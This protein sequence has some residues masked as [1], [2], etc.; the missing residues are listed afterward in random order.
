MFS[1]ESLVIFLLDKSSLR[2]VDWHMSNNFRILFTLYAVSIVG[3]TVAFV[4]Q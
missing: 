3:K 2:I 4:S 1:F